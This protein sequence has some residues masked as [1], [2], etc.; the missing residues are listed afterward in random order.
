MRQQP[1]CRHGFGN[2]LQRGRRNEH[3]RGGTVNAFT[4]LAGIFVANEAD[5]LDF[6]RENVEL[7]PDLFPDAAERTAAG[8]LFLRRLR[9]DITMLALFFGP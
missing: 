8:A 7:F 3:R 5:Y 6:G 1:W 9:D 4:A 2:Q